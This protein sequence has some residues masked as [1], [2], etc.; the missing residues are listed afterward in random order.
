[1]DSS[2][3]FKLPV[4]NLLGMPQSCLNVAALLLQDSRTNAAEVHARAFGEWTEWLVGKNTFAHATQL[5]LSRLIPMMVLKRFKTGQH[6][7][8]SFPASL[9]SVILLRLAANHLQE[10]I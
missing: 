1:M 4:E 8:R 9:E 7:V 5:A 2:L 6:I 10:K 3:F